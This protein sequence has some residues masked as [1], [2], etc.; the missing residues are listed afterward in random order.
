MKTVS[1]VAAKRLGITCCVQDA[2]LFDVA[3]KMNA[4]D[5]S[6]LVVV[7]EEKHLEGI[8]T[9]TDVVR[10][11]LA[12]PEGWR[13]A[14]CQDWMTHNVIT[15]ETTTSL[16]SAARILQSEHIHRVVVVEHDGDALIPIAVISDSDIVYHL[17]SRGV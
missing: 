2:S 1:V 14:S 12:D 5:I 16:E 15:V 7:D 9:R 11:A 8:I 4:E 6:S 3:Q 13:E 10:A 17:V